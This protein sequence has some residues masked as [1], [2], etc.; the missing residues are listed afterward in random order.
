MGVEGGGGREG[1]VGY[2]LVLDFISAGGERW[3]REWGEVRGGGGGRVEGE[4]GVE[5]GG[6]RGGG[7]V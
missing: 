5:G 1:E 3:V 7:G 4:V 6:E 2:S